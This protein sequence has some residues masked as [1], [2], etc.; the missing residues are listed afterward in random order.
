MEMFSPKVEI[1]NHFD[2]LINGVDVDIDECLQN[3][4]ENQVIGEKRIS[5]IFNKI[6]FFKFSVLL[7]SSDDNIEETEDLWS[8]STK[9]VD[10]LK[11]IR[12]RIIE[13]FRK[14][15]KDWVENTS[16][17][18][19]LKVAISDEKQK[20]ELRSQL[21]ADKFYFQVK[22]TKPEFKLWY[23]NLFTFVTDFYMSPSDIDLLE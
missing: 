5:S 1:I 22:I 15:Q 23:F 10:Y 14:E 8:E 20:D 4:N 18:N 11:Q 3:Y 21:F 9:V 2:K 12:M 7:K 19:H 13:E 17:F 16:K 6:S